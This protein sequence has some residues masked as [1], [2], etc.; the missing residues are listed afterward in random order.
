MQVVAIDSDP[1]A[2]DLVAHFLGIAT[3]DNVNA[4]PSG[5]AAPRVIFE[6]NTLETKRGELH[7][8][9]DNAQQR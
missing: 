6:A 5:F 3:H 8:L 2:L 7:L 4:A 9:G 1:A